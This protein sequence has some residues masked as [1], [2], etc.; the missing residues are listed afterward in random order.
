MFN[1]IGLRKLN[2]V[3]DQD[4]LLL[5]TEG[6]MGT[7]M[8]G[9]VPLLITAASYQASAE[10]PSHVGQTGTARSRVRFTLLSIGLALRKC[11]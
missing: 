10:I 5:Y 6:A 1:A 4:T 7:L 11:Q 2:V 8:D 3:I 9:Q